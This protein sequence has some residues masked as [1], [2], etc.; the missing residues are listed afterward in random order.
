MKN[1]I[2]QKIE[3]IV[4]Y[5]HYNLNYNILNHSNYILNLL[6][7]Q[8]SLEVINLINDEIYYKEY[9]KSYN[10]YMNN[11]ENNKQAGLLIIWAIYLII[12][13]YYTFKYNGTELTSHIISN[14]WIIRWMNT[15]LRN[16]FCISDKEFTHRE[17]Y[18]YHHQPRNNGQTHFSEYST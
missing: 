10:Q 6:L 11:E 7:K 9:L 18:I 2:I 3:K 17:E 8:G 4:L 12:T 16:I 13:T 5:L 14:G 15:Q 1:L